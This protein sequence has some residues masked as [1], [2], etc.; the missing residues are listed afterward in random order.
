MTG[1]TNESPLVRVFLFSTFHD[2]MEER[3]LLIK[4]V[5]PRLRKKAKRRGVEL[6]DVDLRWGITEEE[7]KQG[8]VILINSKNHK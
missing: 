7:S 1:E 6:M 3:D 2:F 8:E 4:Q 5:F